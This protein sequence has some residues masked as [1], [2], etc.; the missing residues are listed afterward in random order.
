ML[1]FSGTP[2]AGQKIVLIDAAG[3]LSG[4]FGSIVA[5]GA[6]VTAG[7]DATTFYVIVQ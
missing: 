4:S 1:N 5:N 6:S 7:Q 3:G 2:T